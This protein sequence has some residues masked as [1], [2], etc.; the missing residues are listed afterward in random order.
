MTS[1]PAGDDDDDIH[2]VNTYRGLLQER[3]DR[4]L[5]QK[6]LR[7][8]GRA[9]IR[10]ALLPMALAMA[11]SLVLV[12]VASRHEP[13]RAAHHPPGSKTVPGFY[14]GRI[15]EQLADPAMTRQSMLEQMPGGTEGG[16]NHGS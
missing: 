11:A 2:L 12:W 15:A 7:A 3:P 10:N 6:I 9:R 13:G 14:E 8:A 4:T 16:M 1:G 5:D